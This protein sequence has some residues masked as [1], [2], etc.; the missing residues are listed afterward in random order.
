MDYNNFAV[1]LIWYMGAAFGVGLMGWVAVPKRATRW[2]FMAQAVL[3]A[4]LFYLLLEY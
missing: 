1:I 2:E 3:S 4:G